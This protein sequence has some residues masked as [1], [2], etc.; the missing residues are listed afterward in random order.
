MLHL[1]LCCTSYALYNSFVVEESLNHFLF[2]KCYR[3]GALII[4]LFVSKCPQEF[5]F[6]QDF[7]LERV[8]HTLLSLT[9]YE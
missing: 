7:L 5:L 2:K 4:E 9:Q 6:L 3:L 1:T 8:F